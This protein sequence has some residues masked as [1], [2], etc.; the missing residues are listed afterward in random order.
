MIPNSLAVV[1]GQSSSRVSSAATRVRSIN[2][3]R[4]VHRLGAIDSDVSNRVAIIIKTLL[5]Y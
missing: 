4:L 5:N 2:G 1:A 3:D